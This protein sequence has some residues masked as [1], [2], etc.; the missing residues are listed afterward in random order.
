MYIHE[1]T[2]QPQEGGQFSVP[3]VHSGGYV[4]SVEYGNAVGCGFRPQSGA[5]YGSASAHWSL[6]NWVGALPV[7]ACCPYSKC[8]PNCL[9]QPEQHA[10]WC[11]AMDAGHWMGPVV[12]GHPSVG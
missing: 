8:L 10:H 9:R 6:L 3:I 12:I 7:A 1:I 11:A 2:D 5:Q 4:T